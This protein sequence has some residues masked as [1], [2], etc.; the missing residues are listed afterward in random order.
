MA[1]AQIHGVVVLAEAEALVVV[2]R[3][4]AVAPVVH[5]SLSYTYE[6]IAF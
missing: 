3:L 5:G 1:E 4:V 6:K 2:V